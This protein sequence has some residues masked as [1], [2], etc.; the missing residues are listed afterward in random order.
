MRGEP[1]V[2]E[3]SVT[4]HQH[5]ARRAFSR[6]KLSLDHGTLA[7]VVF[8][9]P[10]PV[11][12]LPTDQSPSLSSQPPPAPAVLWLSPHITDKMMPS[13]GL[14][15]L[16]WML[17]SCL[18]LLSQVQGEDSQKELPSARISCPKGSMAYASYCY[19]LFITTKPGWMQT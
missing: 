12:S 18:M 9:P 13:M 10:T 2:A 6:G 15:S 7:V 16:S 1:A 19:A 11:L 14:P 8:T 5:E 3:A 4:L 17:L